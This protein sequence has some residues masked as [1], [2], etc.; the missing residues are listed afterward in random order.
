MGQD[1]PL[2][3]FTANTANRRNN[4]QAASQVADSYVKLRLRNEQHSDANSFAV[5]VDY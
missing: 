2:F 5:L 1:H 3:V 4:A